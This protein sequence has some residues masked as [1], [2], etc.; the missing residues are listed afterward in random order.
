MGN[1]ATSGQHLGAA[2][3]KV[4]FKEMEA[5]SRISKEYHECAKAK[6]K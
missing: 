6:Q 5:G 3:E 4:G 1:G 2:E